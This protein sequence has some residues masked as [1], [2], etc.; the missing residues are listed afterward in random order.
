MP[1]MSKPS[2]AARTALIY[3]TLGTLMVIWTIIWFIWM[4]DHPESAGDFEHYACVGFLI[5]GIAL[6]VIG[7]AVGQIGRS[8]R[9]AELPPPE[10]TQAEVKAEQNAAARAPVVAPTNPAM[11]TFANPGQAA[12]P[13]AQ[14]PVVPAVPPVASVAPPTAPA[15]RT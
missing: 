7:L 4:R 3:I 8:A 13:I 6:V 1:I 2:S 10:V 12:M 9:H 11:P 14:A 15:R 5:T